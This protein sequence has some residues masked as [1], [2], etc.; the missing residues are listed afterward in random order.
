MKPSAAEPRPASSSVPLR[1]IHGIFFGGFT[2]LCVVAGWPEVEH[3]VDSQLR[4]FNAGPPP[5]AQIV[6]SVL[7]ALVSMAVILVQ[8]LRGRSARLLWS[9]LI[10]L[11]LVLPMW[12][13]QE[14]PLPGRTADSANL[15]I[16]LVARDL[17]NRMVEALQSHGSLPE[18]V[19]S[20]QAALE[21]ISKGEPTTVRTSSFAP[22]PFRVQ[23]LSS[24][25]ALPPDAPPGTLLLHVAQGGVAYELHPVGL[26]ST[27]TPWPLRA[28]DGEPV[29]FRG[30]FNPELRTPAAGGS[31]SRGGH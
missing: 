4:P 30:A 19:G 8:A 21:D 10:L 16:L 24:P 1:A 25:E 27:G 13:T 17:N 6:L 11:A 18:D 14:G 9:I 12:S 31:D 7:V 15:K 5:R 2:A 29:V 22:L 28:S 26:S 23:K 20:W 3:L